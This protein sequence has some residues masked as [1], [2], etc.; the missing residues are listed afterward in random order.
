[1]IAFVGF[2]KGPRYQVPDANRVYYTHKCVFGSR[3]R[4]GYNPLFGSGPSLVFNL[5]LCVAMG[6]VTGPGLDSDTGPISVVS[7]DP[8]I[9]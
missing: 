9:L 7:M 5:N 2:I 1:M 8:G 4:F 6:P 3:F